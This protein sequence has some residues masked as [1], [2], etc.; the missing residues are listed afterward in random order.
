MLC[1]RAQ[2][3]T[4]PYAR[5]GAAFHYACVVSPW[6]TMELKCHSAAAHFTHETVL[7]V[8]AAGQDCSVRTMKT[9]GFFHIPQAEKTDV[10][11]TTKELYHLSPTPLSPSP[12]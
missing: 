9:V 5:P 1:V 7:R 8:D 11:A 3:I 12:S 4:Q 2:M 10:V 6:Q